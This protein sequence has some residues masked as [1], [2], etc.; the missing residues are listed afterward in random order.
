MMVVEIRD[1]LINVAVER[2]V[3]CTYKGSAVKEVD[4]QICTA[5]MSPPFQPD[6]SYS[7]PNYP[8]FAEDQISAF[9]GGQFPSGTATGTHATASHICSE[10]PRGT[11]RTNSHFDGNTSSNFQ[12]SNTF[13]NGPTAFNN[14]TD[15]SNRPLFYF[16]SKIQSNLM[17]AKLSS[18]QNNSISKYQTWV[19]TLMKQKAALVEQKDAVINAKLMIIEAKN[20]LVEEN[21]KLRGEN[22]TLKNDNNS[23]RTELEKYKSF[24]IPWQDSYQ[25]G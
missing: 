2:S 17:T 12:V 10:S 1:Q 25:Y 22:S 14:A 24:S 8:E 11:V 9:L 6:A 4:F 3:E 19:D 20:A 21:I 23:L 15:L 7:G 16:C 5:V 13:T 18:S